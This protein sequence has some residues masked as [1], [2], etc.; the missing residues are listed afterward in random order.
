LSFETAIHHLQW[1]ASLLNCASHLRNPENEWREHQTQQ[2]NWRVHRFSDQTT[3]LCTYTVRTKPS[4]RPALSELFCPVHY[5]LIKPAASFI[6]FSMQSHLDTSSSDSFEAGSTEILK[7]SSFHSG[8]H[9]EEHNSSSRL[10]FLGQIGFEHVGVDRPNKCR[11][12]GC[13]DLSRALPTGD[14]APIELRL[15][16]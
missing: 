13:R 7:H 5:P 2:L 8:I 9:L 4:L 10:N 12:E 1:T 11:P 16:L 14:R 3:R 6:S 15:P